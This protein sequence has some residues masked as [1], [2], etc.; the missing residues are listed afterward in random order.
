MYVQDQENH[1]YTIKFDTGANKTAISAE[2]IFGTLTDQK[3]EAIKKLFEGKV[4]PEICYSAS[5][6]EIMVYPV[7]SNNVII[8]GCE[9]PYF[10]Y[11]LVLDRLKENRKIALLGDNFI[12]CCGLTKKPHEDIIINEFDV[13]NYRISSMHLSMNEIMEMICSK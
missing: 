12:D 3:L 11:Y 6:H 10:Y 5:G 1:T 2:I 8:G 4:Q 9:F 7:V 13:E